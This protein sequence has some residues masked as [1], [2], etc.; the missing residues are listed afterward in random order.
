MFKWLTHFLKKEKCNQCNAILTN[1]DL[2]DGGAVELS[3]SLNCLK[4]SNFAIK[5]P[6][7]NYFIN[8][9]QRCPVVVDYF[10]M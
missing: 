3:T 4:S 5:E 9:I 7:K 2:K 8:L 1:K 10:P 6:K